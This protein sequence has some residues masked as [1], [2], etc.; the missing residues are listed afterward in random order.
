M[1]LNIEKRVC[2]FFQIPRHGSDS[3][4]LI[5]AEGYDRFVRSITSYQRNICPVKGGDHGNINPLAF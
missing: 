3:V 4:R 5:D 2:L 1:I